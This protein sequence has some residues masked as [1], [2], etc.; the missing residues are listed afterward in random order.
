VNV[1]NSA[2]TRKFRARPFLYVLLIC[3]TVLFLLYQREASGP[4]ESLI[5]V[6]RAH[7]EGLRQQHFRQTGSLPAPDEEQALIERFIDDEVMIRE[8][9]AMGMDR[10][11]PIVRRRLVQ[12]ME[13][14]LEEFHDREE[15][16]EEEL[17]ATYEKHRLDFQEPSR[18]SMTHI[19]LDRSGSAERPDREIEQL[20]EQLASGADPVKLGDPFLLGHHFQKRTQ[21]ELAAA[22]G[23]AFAESIRHLP[24]GE[25]FGPVESSYG[26]HLVLVEEIHEARQQ[27]LPEVRPRL[28]KQRK[29]AGRE[30]A[31]RREVRR[32]RGRYDIRFVGTDAEKNTD[33][34]SRGGKF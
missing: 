17:Q 10:G 2:G 14:L 6:S 27:T 23:K 3:L 7:I 33:G 9:R 19:F 20:L 34:S 16:T 31:R 29:A 25:W 32:L 13:S 30:E 26:L 1:S 21:T 12:K 8:A 4:E 5:L 24:E 11:D 22:F 28:I 18:I 15:P